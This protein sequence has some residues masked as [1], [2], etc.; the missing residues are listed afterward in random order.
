MDGTAPCLAGQRALPWGSAA[1][2]VALPADLASLFLPRAQHRPRAAP[3][4][5][6][7]AAFEQSIHQRES[8]PGNRAVWQGVSFRPPPELRSLRAS[9]SLWGL[10]GR[11]WAE[12]SPLTS[13]TGV[14]ACKWSGS[15]PGTHSSDS[16]RT[17][18]RLGRR[19]VAP[20]LRQT[21]EQRE[22]SDL[23]QVRGRWLGTPGPRGRDPSS[24]A[25]HCSLEVWFCFG[26]CRALL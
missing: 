1:H 16:T 3:S 13:A 23:P 26:G 18:H 10:R 22:L 2:P 11:H 25:N 7:G 12:P 8:V 21:P 9:L 14:G 20:A 6:D 24:S 5:G 17:P 19:L 4:D 15:V